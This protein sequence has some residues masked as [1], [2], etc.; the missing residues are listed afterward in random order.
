M[1]VCVYIYIYILETQHEIL[2]NKTTQSTSCAKADNPNTYKVRI[3]ALYDNCL[4]V[5]ELDLTT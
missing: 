2:L 4:H 3:K 1:C 5:P